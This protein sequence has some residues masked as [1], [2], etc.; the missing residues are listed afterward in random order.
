[1]PAHLA[2]S[3]TPRASLAPAEI[4]TFGPHIDSEHVAIVVGDWAEQ[5]VP[6][7]R[8]HSECLTGDVFGSAR[9]DC[10]PQLQEALRL[11]STH[12]GIVLYLRQEGR[13]IGLYNKIDAYRLQDQGLDTYEAN[14][15]LNR[16]ED[17]RDFGVAAKMLLALGVSKCCLLTNNPDKQRQLAEHGID[18]VERRS[19]G[20]YVNGENRSYLETKVARA[21]H[22]IAVPGD[23]TAPADPT[24]SSATQEQT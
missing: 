3:G 7:V 18:V 2:G 6:L 23:R 15:A 8:V 22:D 19:T 5:D 24:P 17:E 16:G 1:M 20:V 11:V 9:C 14:R 10:G 21:H 4:V 13:G 12:G